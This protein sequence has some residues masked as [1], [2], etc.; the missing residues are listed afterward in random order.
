MRYA[1]SDLELKRQ[2]L[3]QVFPDIVAPNA[4]AH[5]LFDPNALRSWLL[6]LQVTWRG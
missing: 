5:V 6:R 4:R 2:A 3:S 1:R